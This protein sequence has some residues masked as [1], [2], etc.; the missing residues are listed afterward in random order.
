MDFWDRD[1]LLFAATTDGFGDLY[2]YMPK[3]RQSIRISRD[4][5]DDLDAGVYSLAE[6]TKGIL[7]SSNRTNL[8]L[9]DRKLDTL[10]PLENFDIYFMYPDSGS[11]RLLN[12]TQT[13][14]VNERQPVAIGPRSVIYLSAESGTWNRKV[15]HGPLS[16]QKDID[17]ITRYNRNIISH[18]SVPGSDRIYEHIV[19]DS[20]HLLIESRPESVEPFS[21]NSMQDSATIAVGESNM[22][23]RDVV[24]ERYL[25][26]SPFKKPE[27]PGDEVVE[28]EPPAEPA[29][30]PVSPEI[31]SEF[32]KT[33]VTDENPVMYDPARVERYRSARAIAHRLR[34]KIDYITATLDNSLLFTELDAYAATKQ[35]YENP[36]LGI[37][38]KAN[39]KDLFED[40]VI[41]GGAR[42]PTTFNGSEYYLFFDNRKRRI[43][44]RFALYR[45][46]MTETEEAPTL[47]PLKDR[48]I[49]L[50]GSFRATYP[51]DAYRSLRGTAYLR[52]DRHI[53]LA[54]NINNLETPIDDAQRFGLKLEYVFDNTIT[55]DVNYLNGTRYKVWAEVVKR[56]DLNLFESGEKLTFNKGFMT[57]L[58]VDARHYQRLDRHAIL[59]LRFMGS[60]SFGSERNLY[61][62]GGVENW[63]F[64]SFDNTIPVPGDKNFAYQTIAAQMRGFKYNARNGSSVILTNTELRIPFVR[65]FSK[66]RIR[67][68]VLRN[69]QVVGFLDVGTAW[70]GP[71]PFSAENPLNTLTLT[72]PPTV[73]VN[74]QYYRNPIVVGYGAGVRTQLLGYF[75][76]LDYAW[77]WDTGKVNDPILYFSL[78]TDF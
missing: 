2:K 43:D 17:Y 66:K 7:F 58:G 57:V 13:P 21:L 5:Y 47:G 32:T 26:Q 28:E 61:Y 63:M 71:D 67:S 35:Q 59:A 48:Y 39:L 36:P 19:K 34:F 53:V 8:E 29:P 51:F 50:I 14:F 46:S 68:S 76:K 65:Y 15:V 62:L 41:E 74:V 33:P 42:F 40:Y 25:F 31:P 11:W 77:G 3:T 9:V 37:L 70:H 38:I 64:S 45:K 6:G 4:F 78:G 1:T 24:D 22:D 16:D 72:N 20:R 23:K 52:N 10:L 44:K 73:V 75:L 56:F 27:T 12:L 30:P 69:L 55:I 60:T 54:T 49:S 18:T